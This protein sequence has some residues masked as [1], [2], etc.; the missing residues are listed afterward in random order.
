[1][2]QRVLVAAVLSAVVAAGGGASMG[3]SALSPQK[4]A[5][6][7]FS[8][9]TVSIA[10]YK[11]DRGTYVGMTKAKLAQWDYAIVRHPVRIVWTTKTRYCLETTVSGRLFHRVGPTGVLTSAKVAAPPG[12]CP[13]P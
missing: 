12:R 1:M 11:E 9:W 2:R 7:R 13:A 5:W 6:K 8:M 4:V 3:L 10:V